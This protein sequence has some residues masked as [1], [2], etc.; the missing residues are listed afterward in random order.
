MDTQSLIASL[1]A[2]PGIIMGLVREVSPQTLKRRPAS[3]K[4]SAH[5][6]PCHISGGDALFLSRLELMLSH[7]M[8]LIK[9]LEPS[10]EEE[11][12]SLLSLD[13]DEAL[14]LYVRERCESSSG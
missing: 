13:L 8:P 6:H 12:G 3:N 7:P 4:W 11:A 1:E 10:P 2:A 5:E 14:H 9:S